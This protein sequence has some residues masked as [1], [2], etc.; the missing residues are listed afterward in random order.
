MERRLDRIPPYH[1]AVLK[2]HLAS[3]GVDYK[4]MDKPIIAVVNSHN[5]FVAGHVP[6]RRMG[7]IVKD[8]I[9]EAGGLPLEFN[10]IAMCD[11]FGQGHG[12]MRYSLPSRDIIADSVETMILGHDIFDGVVM[13]AS[14]DKIVPAMLMAAARLNLPTVIVTGGPSG[15]VIT[16]AQS[17][18]ARQRFLKGEIDEEELVR[19]TAQ[20]YN[21]PG[22][23]SF[24]GT[25]NTMAMVTE[26]LGMSLPGAALLPSESDERVELLR[27]SGRR[28]LEIAVAGGPL[29]RE[30]LTR[31]AFDDA[32]ALVLGIGGSLNTVLHLPAIAHEVGIELTLDDWE[33]VSRRTPFICAVTPNHNGRTV[34]DLRRAGGTGAVLKELLPVLN[35][36]RI[37]V[38]GRS[39]REN[40][41]NDAVTDREVIHP[42]AAPLLASG[43]IQ[44]LRGNLAAEGALI[45]RSAAE[46]E[47]FRGPARVFEA[48]EAAE[49][50]ATHGQVQPG[51]VLVVRY[52]GPKGGP[53][54]R[55]LHRL[56]EIIKKIGNVAVIT[57]GRF[58]GASAG[59]AIG[60]LGPE[61][62]EGGTIALVKDGDMIEI[63]LTRAGVTLEVSE[64]ELAERRTQWVLK[65]KEASLLLRQYAQS[66]GPAWGGAVRGCGA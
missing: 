9:R 12:G 20:Y 13:L 40:V 45:K 21:G 1:R 57:D 59:M 8:A 3:C 46:T 62:A 16:P 66:V 60:Y 44:V 5:D 6:L 51:D 17:K 61:A 30:I 23:C 27:A 52:E 43:G 29:P 10:T 14:C 42:F 25:A 58:S 53:G 64:A 54:M 35:G 65:E 38:T 48:E 24:L 47:Y 18:D 33:R 2:G 56:T 15:N 28:A 49:E 19:V 34:N 55:E 26:G 7:E 32:I 41:N 50:A 11:A 63:D 37:T 39:L 22:V 31:E 36:E 4:D